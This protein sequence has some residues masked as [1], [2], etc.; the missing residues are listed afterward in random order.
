VQ[1]V[2]VGHETPL[3]ALVMVPGSGLATMDHVVP[4]KVSIS[5]AVIPDPPVDDPT[6]V[7]A[8]EVVHD[9]AVRLLLLLATFWLV[10]DVHV[11]PFHVSI[12]VRIVPDPF[13]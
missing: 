6:A 10:A 4:L 7:Q 1:L 2:E 9:T 5:V 8:V 12:S 11:L 3:S 13:W